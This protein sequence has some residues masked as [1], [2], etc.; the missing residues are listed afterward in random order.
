MLI[1]E[2]CPCPRCDWVSPGSRSRSRSRS[3]ARVGELERALLFTLPTVGLSAIL[4]FLEPRN[5]LPI[6]LIALVVNGFIFALRYTKLRA[7]RY[8]AAHQVI[9]RNP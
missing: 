5:A 7:K 6:L 2:L 8:E 1:R 9:F 3:R 4:P